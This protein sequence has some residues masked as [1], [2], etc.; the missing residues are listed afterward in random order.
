MC[1]E[2]I[3]SAVLAS[4]YISVSFYSIAES[5]QEL[6]NVLLF[7]SCFGA[8]GSVFSTH[9]NYYIDQSRIRPIN[10]IFYV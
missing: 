8:A 4:I 1:D 10:Q 5:E 7:L 9:G 6:S 2:R 3:V